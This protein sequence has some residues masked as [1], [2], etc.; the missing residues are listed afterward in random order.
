M[1]CGLT[2]MYYPA[3]PHII[4]SA[5]VRAGKQNL[6]S[7][8]LSRTGLTFQKN[9]APLPVRAV[10]SAFPLSRSPFWAHTWTVYSTPG[11]RPVR[12]VLLCSFPTGTSLVSPSAEV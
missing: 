11:L 10:V 8:R 6:T 7:H 1:A 3:F 2:E 9:D 12:T 4:N 5:S